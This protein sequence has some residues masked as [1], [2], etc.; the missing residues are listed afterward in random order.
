MR[1]RTQAPRFALSGQSWKPTASAPPAP[2]RSW[3]PTASAPPAP[4]RSWKPTA[5]AP[6]APKRSWKPTATAS[7]APNARSI[8]STAPRPGDSPGPCAQS[9]ASS[10]GD[11][12][13][14]P[15]DRTTL[16][17]QLQSNHAPGPH[18]EADAEGN[19]APET[20]KVRLI[21]YFL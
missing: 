10:S 4:K 2:K 15:N 18:W 1:P 7:P 16:L 6:P 12:E 5:A 14:M 17:G 9:V 19:P 11:P 8:S 3:K 21:A 20:P 13:P